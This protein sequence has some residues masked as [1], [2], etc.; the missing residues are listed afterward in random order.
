[1]LRVKAKPGIK[2]PLQHRP[3]IYIPDERFVEVEDSHYYRSM[4]SAGDLV[5]AT[6]QEWAAQQEADA[7]AEAAAI[8][9]DKK[10][11]A[12]AAKAAKA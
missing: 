2:A 5:E 3:K 4:V 12:E 7:K 6:D 11:K 10:A 8:A 1:M 9:A